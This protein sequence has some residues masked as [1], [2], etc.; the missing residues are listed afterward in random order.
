VSL[1]AVRSRLSG[2]ARRACGLRIPFV[3]YFQDPAFAKEH[4]EMAFDRDLQVDWEPGLSDG[5]TSARFAVVD[6]DADTGRVEAPT[7]WDLDSEQFLA[8]GQPVDLERVGTPQFRQVSVWA[9]LQRA[10]AF[11]EE[12]NGLGRRIPWAF[13]GNRLVVVPAA[14]YGENAF[15]DRASR[16]LQFYYFGS[17]PDRVYTCLSADIVHH[18][19]GHAV[20]DGIRPYYNESSSVQ[21][22]AFHE[23]MGDLTAILLPLRNNAFRRFL[24]DQSG[25]QLD[26]AEPLSSIA[27][28]FGRA[29]LGQPELRN[30]RNTLHLRDLAGETSPHRLSELLTGTMFDVLRELTRTSY[31][32]EAGRDPAT[33]AGKKARAKSKRSPREA[34]WLAAD[35]MQR[36]ALQPL[37]LLP[38]VEVTFRDY[39]IAVCR[40]EQLANPLDPKGYYRM[41]LE[42]FRNRGILSDADAAELMTAPVPLQPPAPRRPPR[43]RRHRPLAR[44]RVSVPR[45]QPRRPAHPGQSRFPGRRSLRCPE[46]HARTL[47]DAAPDRPRV[48]LARRRAARRNPLRPVRGRGH[49]DALRRHPRLRRHRHRPRL[50]H[51]TRFPT[52]RRQTPPRRRRPPTLGERPRRRRASPRH[53]ARRP[54]R[55]DRRRPHRQPRRHQP[56]PARLSHSA[57]HHGTGR[58]YGPLPPLPAPQPLR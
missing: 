14:G 28:E 1:Y 10:L 35:R 41:L 58:R 26:R 31:Q 45:R 56:G 50:G 51:Q 20:L 52:L 43:H 21:T 49:P 2:S 8:D 5:P 11:F 29:V 39:A 57:P 42:V 32:E 55:P 6:Y 47:P 33:P 17:E 3:T 48:C 46:T 13:E 54:R 34:F 36:M 9:L 23:F 7:V 53:A 18:E 44:G 4:P 30:A 19:F 37:D 24:A 25:G 40:A 27:E 22:A 15:Y 12:G 38:P 16:S